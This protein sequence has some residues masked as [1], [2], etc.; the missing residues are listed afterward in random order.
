[1]RLIKWLYDLLLRLYP[2]D[3]RALFAAEMSSV[4]LSAAEEQ[5]RRGRLALTRLACGELFGLL[6]GALGEWTARVLEAVFRG[7]TTADIDLT[8]MRPPEVSSQ[9]YTAAIDEVLDARRQVDFNLHRMTAA[10]SRNDFVQARFYSDEE[11][12]ARE[13]WHLVQRKHGIAE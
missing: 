2:A 8:R 5:R 9:T 13:Y 1:M 4:F 11:R 12:K 6:R 3:V 10:L 7:R